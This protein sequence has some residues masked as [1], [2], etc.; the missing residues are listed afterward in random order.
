[1]GRL[2]IVAIAVIIICVNLTGCGRKY[3]DYERDWVTSD[4]TIR[5]TP[6]GFMTIDIDEVD[7]TR[8]ITA[9][10]DSGQT[11]LHIRYE[12]SGQTASEKKIW[13]AYAIIRGNTLYLKVDKDYVSNYEG[14][15]FVLTQS[16]E[17]SNEKLY[18]EYDYDWVSEDKTVRI[19]PD[20]QVTMDIVG[21][22]QTQIVNVGQDSWERDLKFYYANQAQ[23]SSKKF[24]WKAFT[25]IREDT[26]YLYIY[27][28][29]VS[30]YQGKV[31]VL[32]QEDDT[33][34]EKP[35]EK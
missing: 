23:E 13:D 3:C 28:D 7:Q 20:G 32:T 31:V 35:T 15:T 4:G 2:K 26:L 1:M 12:A 25:E 22:D 11:Y 6:G 5:L 34:S 8:F 27:K 16:K 29:K 21:V 14:T 33:S 19:T 30:E 24:I 17:P 10:S 9:S 18:S